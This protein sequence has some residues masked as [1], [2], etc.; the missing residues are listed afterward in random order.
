MGQS[1]NSNIF[2]I[3]YKNNEW[4]S[5]YKEKNKE[6][7]FI[8]VYQDLKV[9]KLI[10]NFLKYFNILVCF[11]KLNRTNKFLNVYISFY[12]T[13][14]SFYFINNFDLNKDYFILEKISKRKIKFF[15]NKRFIK[16][17]L[18]NNRL[19]DIKSLKI[20]KL[21]KKLKIKTF[22]Y[23]LL[24]SIS[25]FLNF[26]IN[27]SIILQNINKGLSLRFKNLQSKL[28]RKKIIKLRKYFNK[29]F[30]K[31]TVNIITIVIYKKF[32]SKLLSNFIAYQI[33]NLKSHN[34]FLNFIKRVFLIF[35]NSNFSSI[36]GLKILINGR[37]NGKPRAKSYLIKEGSINLQTLDSD[38]DYNQSTAYTHDGT[39]GVKVWINRKC[40]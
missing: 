13:S 12:I 24:E 10:E 19:W 15:K 27:V 8:Y 40:L 31:E 35:L 29:E 37:L 6:E 33:E 38:I 36:N 9:R 32:S 18:N 11:I 17:K 1:T 5:K 23:K 4:S 2:R 14:K 7:K 25:I 39:L 22:F 34:F 21:Y 16:K 26:K 20:N 30:F 28:F 3:G